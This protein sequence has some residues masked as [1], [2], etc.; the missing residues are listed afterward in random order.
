MFSWRNVVSMIGCGVGAV[1]MVACGPGPS[2]S[3]TT[4]PTRARGEII[5]PKDPSPPAVANREPV[6][7]EVRT[8]E[9]VTIAVAS[10]PAVSLPTTNPAAPVRP[11]SAESSNALGFD[12]LASYN[13]ETDQEHPVTN[14]PAGSDIANEQ[15]PSAIKALT[16]RRYAIKGFM[17]PLKVDGGSVTEFLLMKDQSMCCFGSVPKITEWI[18]VKSVGKGMKPI[19]D[20]AVSIE[21]ILHVGA[22]RENGYLVGIYQMDGEKMLVTGPE[23]N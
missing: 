16:D 22:I 20:Q 21:G 8:N 12:K 2:D 4:A 15:I 17:L 5:A 23:K 19:M 11:A 13:F 1:V 9:P 14:S 18:N 6:R 3:P 7:P 10:V